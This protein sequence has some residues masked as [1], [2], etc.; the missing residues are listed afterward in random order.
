[1]EY[2]QGSF[3][4]SWF[5]HPSISNHRYRCRISFRSIRWDLQR[6]LR[7]LLLD[8]IDSFLRST[9]RNPKSSDILG[10][11]Q[12]S[13]HRK[14][15]QRYTLCRTW[16]L[17]RLYVQYGSI[18]RHHKVGSQHI[19]QV[20]YLHQSHLILTVTLRSRCCDP[21]FGIL[22]IKMFWM[23]TRLCCGVVFSFNSA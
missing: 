11:I 22:C 20:A 7:R 21:H 3:H 6:G 19:F 16:C 18:F 17:S 4:K 1:M 14:L 23:T 15:H 10:H 8:R 2:I 13:C 9:I 5:R 12:L